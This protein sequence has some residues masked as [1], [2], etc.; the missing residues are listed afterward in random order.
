M[1]KLFTHCIL[2]GNAGS[3]LSLRK[4]FH[5]FRYSRLVAPFAFGQPTIDSNFGVDHGAQ[6]RQCNPTMKAPSP[7][8]C[9][10]IGVEIG[11]KLVGSKLDVLHRKHRP[12]KGPE[13]LLNFD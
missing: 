2:K 10:G 6:F 8:Y 1:L 4:C 12:P 7:L 5:H 9:L 3:Q 13:N 11:S